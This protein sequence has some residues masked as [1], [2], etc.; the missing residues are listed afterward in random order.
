MSNKVYF[1]PGPTQLY[2]TIK[3]HLDQ[4]LKDDVASI[5]HRSGAFQDIYKNTTVALKEVVGLP[6]NY[7]IFF[8]SSATEIFERIIKNLS[9]E[10]SYHFVNGSFSKRFY[11]YAEMSGRKAGIYE[12]PFSEGFDVSKATIASNTELICFTHNETSSGVSV[13]LEDIYTIRTKHPE[14]IIAMDGVSSLPYPQV[15]YS[16]IDTAFFS[17]Q[18]C[19]GLPAG[20]GVWMVNE[21]AIAKSKALQQK[22]VIIGPHHDLP[23]FEL[24]GDKNQ[25]PSTPNVLYIYLLG[26]VCE[27]LLRIGM[28]NVRREIDDKAAMLYDFVERS[29]IFDN[30]VKNENHRSKTV[31]VANTKVTANEIN[32]ILAPH[33]LVIGSGYGS[34]KESQVR[35]ANFP[36]HSIA[37]TEKLVEQL[38]KSIQY[39]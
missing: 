20:L 15:D 36:S 23:E 26:K 5:S 28:A 11:E 9:E 38:S 27:D 4:A 17:V 14:A 34:Y 3:K 31:V 1:T 16:K 2:P 37:T 39:A 18:K 24:R 12:A 30:S 6:D 13:P 8:L 25:T 7:K 33:D 10:T 21:R 29:E 35:I 19:F 32:K 22:G